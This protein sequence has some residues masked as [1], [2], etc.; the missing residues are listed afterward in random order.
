MR[1]KFV[2][3]LNPELQNLIEEA[4]KETMEMFK[5]GDKNSITKFKGINQIAQIKVAQWAKQGKLVVPQP[6]KEVNKRFGDKWHDIM[7]KKVIGTK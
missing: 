5:L 2:V 4:K 1:N 3:R 7:N 6:P